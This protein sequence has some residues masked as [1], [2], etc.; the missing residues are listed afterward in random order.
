[1]GQGRR[2][3]RCPAMA[4]QVHRCC[5]MTPPVSAC[6]PRPSRL[7]LNARWLAF[8]AARSAAYRGHKEYR[9]ITRRRNMYQSPP[10]AR[11]PQLQI[12]ASISA[13]SV[14]VT[15][16]NA[17]LAPRSGAASDA[18]LALMRLPPKSPLPIISAAP[19][20]PDP[21]TAPAAAAAAAAAS[22]LAAAA[23]CAHGGWRG[24]I[25]CKGAGMPDP[26]NASVGRD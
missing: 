12:S 25:L 9:A 24:A 26:L 22:Q 1:M 16:S 3:N 23:A 20:P 6:L 7:Q 21:P 19:L 17:M 11:P 4:K 5:A 2:R 10:P 18:K 8:H 13:P 15:P 14:S